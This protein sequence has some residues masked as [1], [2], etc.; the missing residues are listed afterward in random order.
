MKLTQILTEKKEKAIVNIPKEK[1]SVMSASTEKL[2][3]QKL[4]EG[5]L[6]VGAKLPPFALT[7]PNGNTV[8]SEDLLAKGKIILT[9]YRGG[10]CPY[11]NL[12]LKALQD[13]Y[14]EF[15]QL[16]ALLVAISPE[17]PDNSLTTAE[18]ND[19]KFPVL[20]DIG[21]EYAKKLGLV[22]K[23]PTDLQDVYSGFGLDVAKHNGNK[24]FELPMPATFIVEKDGTV[25]KAFVPEDY[26]ERLDP[27][28]ILAFLN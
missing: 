20:S 19:L 18:K 10:W 17:T 22:F 12:E 8:K 23:M 5:A 11:C 14:Q 25:L 13:H 6:K 16:N 9:F 1:Y 15:E 21:N 2:K 4:S 3:E 27:A 26:T 28:D 7:D 24:D